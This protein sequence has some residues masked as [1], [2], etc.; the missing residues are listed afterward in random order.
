MDFTQAHVLIARA[1]QGYIPRFEDFE[2]AAWDRTSPIND[3][4]AADV[5][6]GMRDPNDTPIPDAR[7]VLLR[8]TK[9]DVVLCFQAVHPHTNMPLYDDR[10]MAWVMA[11][12]SAET[13]PR[14]MMDPE[15]L[16]MNLHA[17]LAKRLIQGALREAQG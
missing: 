9:L 5:V 2:V 8:N 7:P 16:K 3:V 17:A 11:W 10:E 15:K 1:L 14:L 13:L 12:M 4:P 6:A